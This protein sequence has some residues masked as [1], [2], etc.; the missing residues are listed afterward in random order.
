MRKRKF[1]PGP[2]S[3]SS[4]G[5][6]SSSS[7]SSSTAHGTIVKARK[8]QVDFAKMD[9]KKSVNEAGL[10]QMT[11]QR[12]QS[13]NRQLSTFQGTSTPKSE[14]IRIKAVTTA[15]ENW[16]VSADENARTEFQRT[17]KAKM[18]HDESETIFNQRSHQG[19]LV[20]KT[21]SPTLAQYGD[22]TD[23]SEPLSAHTPGL[24]SKNVPGTTGAL[25]KEHGT[26]DARREQIVTKTFS[27]PSRGEHDTAIV[28]KL[29]T[30]QLFMSPEEELETASAD[31][32]KSKTPVIS[33]FKDI[34]TVSGSSQSAER[35]TL[36]KRV[37]SVRE[38]EKMHAAR[39]LLIAGHASLV[40]PEHQEL[41]RQTGGD[42][43]KAMALLHQEST[44]SKPRIRFNTATSSAT[45]RLD[46][47]SLRENAAQKT[48]QRA[49][50]P[51]RRTTTRFNRF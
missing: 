5:S 24:K 7:S 30:I 2:A 45:D 26:R 37:Q 10:W 20:W 17:K 48:P 8:R 29:A 1:D 44:S 31:V 11:G 51:P 13:L 38:T 23:T 42:V 27:D 47:M 19:A 43:E 12:A 32:Q 36:F 22:K 46:Q 33:Q 40:S 41:L 35:T 14:T 6:G 34:G 4:S 39:N 3:S 9:L 25:T 21:G 28:S 18:S 50:S 15:N 16:G 49:L